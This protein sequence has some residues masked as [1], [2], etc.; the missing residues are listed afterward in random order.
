MN[1]P[2]VEEVANLV[3]PTFPTKAADLRLMLY[4]LL[5]ISIHHL[6]LDLA[7]CM[8][9]FTRMESYQFWCFVDDPQIKS[10]IS[11]LKAWN[12]MHSDRTV[13]FNRVLFLMDQTL[14]CEGHLLGDWIKDNFS[15][16]LVVFLSFLLIISKVNIYSF[17]VQ[18][19]RLKPLRQKLVE[20]WNKRKHQIW[21]SEHDVRYSQCETSDLTATGLIR[22]VP[23]RCL[24]EKQ[25]TK[26]SLLHE[27]QLQES[28][29]RLSGPFSVG[30]FLEER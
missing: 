17:C 25:L 30:P 11:P 18:T 16:L 2:V 9:V 15:F 21:S 28:H 8:P 3:S 13:L 5:T 27:E 1:R 24:Q 4:F 10:K 20:L 23:L 19:K 12:P 6:T 26:L 22:I 7:V 29:R 14:K